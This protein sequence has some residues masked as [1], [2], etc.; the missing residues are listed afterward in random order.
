MIGISG[1]MIEVFSEMRGVSWQMRGVQEHVQI[2]PRW[3]Y[4]IESEPFNGG[5]LQFHEYGSVVT[6]YPCTLERNDISRFPVRIV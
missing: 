2:R 5:E 1:Q 6:S 4:S 3:S